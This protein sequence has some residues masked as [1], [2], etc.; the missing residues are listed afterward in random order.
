ML[1]ELRLPCSPLGRPAVH[2]AALLLHR[3]CLA[4]R[5]PKGRAAWRWK[6]VRFFIKIEQ[7]LAPQSAPELSARPFL[8]DKRVLFRY[9]DSSSELCL[10]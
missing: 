3:V 4:G 1:N 10:R 8:T 7:I 9:T 5:I 2:R 6:F